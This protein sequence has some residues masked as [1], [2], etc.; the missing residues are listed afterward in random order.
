[1]ARCF[2]CFGSSNKEKNHTDDDKRGTLNECSSSA[3]F[4]RV[5]SS[6]VPAVDRDSVQHVV[7]MRHG[8]RIDNAEPLWVSTAARPFDPPLAEPGKVRAFC[9]GRKLRNNL[10]FPIHRVFVS[11]FLRCIQTASE[12]ISA[13]CAIN[14]D[15][16]EMTSD[17]IS[18]DPSKV[19]ASIEYGLCELL[20]R[21][22][23]GPKMAPKNGNWG[24][25]VSELESM[26]PAGTVDKSVDRVYKELPRW[27]ESI[28]EGRARYLR[29]IR[30]LADKFPSENL[31]FVTH[32]EGIG[33]AVT[34]F[35]KDTTVYGVEYCAYAHL[36]RQIFFSSSGTFTTGNF[37]IVIPQDQ[38]GVTTVPT[39][40]LALNL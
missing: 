16:L 20:N 33:A 31:L 34:A 14:D 24:F 40:E 1:M 38:S 6:S 13:L 27:E 35:M 23:I 12:V 19:K 18:I 32:G 25:N 10:G 37:E 22:A 15:P 3:Q 39:S 8:D 5:C 30:A 9:T 36:H 17:N 29:V 26:L 21:E 28:M 2:S 7:V 11:P 4:H